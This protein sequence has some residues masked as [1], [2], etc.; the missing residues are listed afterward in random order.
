M[1]QHM[2]WIFLALLLL[3]TQTYT[4]A[5]RGDRA[6]KRERLKALKTAFIT[7]ELQLTS[8]QAEQFWPI[9]NELEAEL[10]TL[11]QK[12]HKKDFEGL[13]EAET[14]AWVREQLDME[15]EQAAIK[16]RY[17]DRLVT[18]LDWKQ[19]ARLLRVEHRFKQE[20]LRRMKERRGR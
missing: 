6:S 16:R 18:V 15:A 11:R 19:I 5:Q 4:M 14:E 8:E 20:I 7:E 1:I 12:R 3:T 13:N 9:Y 10:R 2:K 17:L